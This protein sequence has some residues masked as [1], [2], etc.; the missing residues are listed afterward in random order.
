MKDKTDKV[1]NDEIKSYELAYL[2]SPLVAPEAV[3]ERVET[4]IKKAL[5]LARA[6]LKSEME[7]TLRSL[8]YPIKKVVE[9]KGST[10]R[11][12]YFG[13]LIFEAESQT[14]PVLEASIRQSAL[15]IRHLLIALPAR[16]FFV[17]PV[18]QHPVD[19]PTTPEVS[20]VEKKAK[21]NPAAMDQE[22]EQLLVTK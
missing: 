16:A 1:K 18:R 17:P 6:T 10:F 14:I 11:E 4:E 7:P 15:V 13:S 3:G 19:T 8:A 20:E 2:L 22:I 21:A 5:T 9:H 12:A